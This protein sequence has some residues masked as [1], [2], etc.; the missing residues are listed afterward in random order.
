MSTTL[1]V[2]KQDF[3]GKARELADVFRAQALASET[4]RSLSDE[5]VTAFEQS[6]LVRLLVP[7][8]F[9]GYEQ[10]FR[11][12]VDVL[13]AMGAGDGSAGWVCGY[14][15]EHSYL[16]ALFPAGG[17]EAV[18]ADGPDAR[19]STSFAPRGTVQIVDGGYQV[20]GQ[21]PWCSGVDHA[22]WMILGGLVFSEG[23]PPH[24]RLFL[25]P[26][27]DYRV[28]DTWHNAGLTGT[29]SNDVV[30]E[31]VFVP[32]E[33]TCD[34][35][36]MR[37]GVSP[38]GQVNDNPI[39]HVP[40]MASELYALVATGVGIARGAVDAWIGFAREKV[41]SYSG[42]QIAEGAPLQ[43]RLAE[44]TADIDAADLLL[45]RAVD[46]LSD[47]AG[48]TMEIRVRNRRDFTAA[49]RKLVQAVDSLLQVGG[50]SG[51][52]LSNPIQRGWRDVHAI[53]THIMMNFENAGQN[54]GRMAL[55][56][57]LNPKDPF[58]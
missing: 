53:S 18:W 38:G 34:M 27:S 44:L 2:D 11:Y 41:Q 56:Q 12:A 8:R 7:A 32:E 40:F 39:Y 55:G 17:Q 3:L 48:V 13:E 14:W 33:R 29:G 19:V 24:L 47:T 15:I 10:D 36:L 22:S 23:Q 35:A 5:T 25:V 46:S 6:G 42:E 57:P 58:F 43:I 49:M 52:F 30:L 37:E 26:N 4:K 20:T 54:F 9:G 28:V 16:V 1:V 51:L 50:A 21:W 45:R 31:S